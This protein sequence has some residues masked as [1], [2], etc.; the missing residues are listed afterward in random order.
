MGY[1]LHTDT[2]VSEADT[3]SLVPPPTAPCTGELANLYSTGPFTIRDALHQ[4]RK[5]RDQTPRDHGS[6]QELTLVQRACVAS[7][8]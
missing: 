6:P 1:F 5:L 8:C 7:V 3:R 4:A 2:S